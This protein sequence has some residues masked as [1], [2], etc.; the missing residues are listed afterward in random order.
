MDFSDK[1]TL[2]DIKNIPELAEVKD[3]LLYGGFSCKILERVPI[4]TM[5]GGGWKPEE[6]F[7]TVEKLCA[8][9]KQGTY[10]Y[11]IY[12]KEDVKAEKRKRDCHILH[13]PAQEGMGSTAGRPYIIVCAGGAY[14]SIWNLHEA[15]PVAMLFSELGY[16][17]FTLNYRVGGKG[18][19]PR[20]MEDLA[21]AIRFIMGH[22]AELGVEG[23]NYIVCGFSAGGNLTGQ[24]GTGAHGYKAY[25]L[26]KPAALF[27]VYPAV[28][29]NLF[30]QNKNTEKFMETMFGRHYSQETKD[31][32][33]I[34]EQADKDFPPSYI[35]CCHDDPDVPCQNSIN[36]KERLEALGVPVFLEIGEKGGHGFGS[37][38]G[39]DVEGWTQRAI[40]FYQGLQAADRKADNTV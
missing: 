31:S 7:S 10:K 28:N 14:S 18:L 2:R 8:R 27:P 33:N 24:W 38:V 23:A 34:D 16:H 5:R 36:L 29:S 6:I 3:Y 15:Y 20:P 40:A 19:M 17:A 25:G 35:V 30:E 37:G 1:T 32:Y 12:T 39:T 26:P 4:G 9:A 21:Q 13:F 22:E 11:D